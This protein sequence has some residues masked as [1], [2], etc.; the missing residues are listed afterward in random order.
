MRTD[1]RGCQKVEGASISMSQR[2]ERKHFITLFQQFRT[3]TESHVAGQ[4]VACQHHS[5]AES[6][7]AGSIVQQHHLIVGQGGVEHIFFPESLRI[8]I[9][10]VLIDMLQEFLYCFSVPLV[11]AT[12]VGQ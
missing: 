8:S 4:V 2:K 1:C 7:G 3:D 6:G 11:Q 12:E 10:H 5:F 9:C